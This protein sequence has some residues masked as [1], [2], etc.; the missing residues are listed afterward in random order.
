VKDGSR[1]SQIVRAIY[2][3]SLERGYG[4]TLDEAR[5]AYAAFTGHAPSRSFTAEIGSLSGRGI[6]SAS[7]RAGSLRYVVSGSEPLLDGTPPR[8]DT[9]ILLDALALAVERTGTMVPTRAISRMIA[10]QGWALASA[11]PNAVRTRLLNL[12]RTHARKGRDWFRPLLRHVVVPG[13]FGRPLSYW[14]PIERTELTPP[15]RPRHSPVAAVR[16]LVE[17][18]NRALGRLSSRTELASFLGTLPEDDPLLAHFPRGKRIPVSTAVREVAR[19]PDTTG[20]RTFTTS[21]TAHGGAPLRYWIGTG[22]EAPPAEAAAAA[23]L[24]DYLRAYRLDAEARQIERLAHEVGRE[25]ED[26]FAPLLE[27][28]RAALVEVAR[29]LEAAL[30]IPLEAAAEHARA[31]DRKLLELRRQ[32]ARKRQDD[33]IARGVEQRMRARDRAVRMLVALR[34]QPPPAGEPQ[35]RVGQSGA[36][37]LA[38][39]EPLAASHTELGRHGVSPYVS[40]ARRFPNPASAGEVRMR[41]AHGVPDVSA[42]GA[43]RYLSLVDRAEALLALADQWGDPWTRALLR[44]A[45]G[46]LGEI[47]R[48]PELVRDAAVAAVH[49]EDVAPTLRRRLLVAAALLDLPEVPALAAEMLEGENGEPLLLDNLRATVLATALSAPSQVA[50]LLGVATERDES[51]EL[52]GVLRRMEMRVGLGRHLS[53]AGA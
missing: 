35:P 1:S 34:D 5:A 46:V 2:A 23:H 15:A 21:L 50:T 48:A 40:K 22:Q 24:D 37:P 42:T 7:G 52:D 32:H 13:R 20:V 31:A 3:A 16:E 10:E 4:L 14:A 12:A 28:R 9:D 49:S 30:P 29:E 27:A 25:A 8:T 6:L 19:R 44:R 47:V 18:C 53:V 33:S 43:E 45:Y 26:L 11:D 41:A 17:R 39:L 36:V 51:L 38:E